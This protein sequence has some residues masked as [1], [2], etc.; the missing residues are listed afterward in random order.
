VV[1][2]QHDT[3]IDTAVEG[4]GDQLVDTNI[5]TDIET[6]VETTIDTAEPRRKRKFDRGLFIASVVIA[7]G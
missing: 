7:C 1:S 4:P 2:D 6:N 5:D 3:A